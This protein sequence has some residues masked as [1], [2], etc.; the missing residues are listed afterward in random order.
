LVRLW[1]ARGGVSLWLLCLG[2]G[3]IFL[4][5]IINGAGGFRG[6]PLGGPRGGL[7]GAQGAT[8]GVRGPLPGGYPPGGPL[9]AALPTDNTARLEPP[10]G[11][12]FLGGPDSLGAKSS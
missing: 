9:V 11:G 7:C 1:W 3:I 8:G 5:N 10:P 6:G 4:L 2:A 12:P